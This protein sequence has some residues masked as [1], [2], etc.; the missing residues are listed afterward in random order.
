MVRVWV[1]NGFVNVDEEKMS[2]S[3]G[4]F[5]TIS[6]VLARNDPEGFR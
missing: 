5:V 4:N 3:L 6:D 2:K 1:H